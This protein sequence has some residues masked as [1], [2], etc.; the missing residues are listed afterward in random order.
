MLTLL[1]ATQA[2]AG[3]SPA[4][5]VA[6][7]DSY[8]VDEDQV[9]E[10]EAPGLLEN[11]EPGPTT[12][13]VSVEF[14]DLAGDLQFDQDG[15]FT[16]TPD[17]HWNGQTTFTYGIQADG[18]A[19]CPGP[20]ESEATVTITVEPV[21]DPPS[22]VADT[23]VALPNRTLNVSAPGVLRNDSDIDG[24][25][26]T[27]SKVSNPVHGV[28]TLAAD[29]SFSYTPSD[30]YLG[31]DSFS[32]RA[33]DG[34]AASATRVVS[35]TVAAIPTPVPTPVPTPSPAPTAAPAA[36]PTAQPSPS[37]SPEPSASVEPIPTPSSSPG[38][39]APA[40]TPGASP[41]PGGTADGGGLSIPALVVGLLLLSLLAFGGAIYVPRWL[42]S[43]RG[44]G[45]IDEG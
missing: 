17:E 27:A 3:V 7:D 38:A 21:N 29:G 12:C 41:L 36:T 44:G 2:L 39:T 1:P 4:A 42:E 32:Y 13:V 28:V 5:P 9:L 30:G 23:F 25:A 43:R 31:P 8:T 22:A 37:G 40:A 24:D 14:P 34:T 33:S 16:Y 11:D 20:Q 10:V 19:E 18:G 6:D 26:L 45:P 35:L 15:S